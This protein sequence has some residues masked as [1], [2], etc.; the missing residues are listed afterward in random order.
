[1]DYYRILTDAV[2]IKDAFIINIGI[3]FE[4][5]VLSNF[6]SN[7][8]LL[9]CINSVR[10]YFNIDKWQINQPIIQSEILNLIANVNGVQSVIGVSSK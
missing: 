5:S 1:M 8:V 9:N 7:E 10:N 2:N 4:I 6:N 3:E